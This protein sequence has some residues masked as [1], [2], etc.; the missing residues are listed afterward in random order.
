MIIVSGLM[1]FD[2]A[3]QTSV[4][5]AAREL[6]AAT[7]QEPGCRTYGL[8]SDPDRP[9]TFRIFEEWEDQESLTAHFATPHFAAFGE[10]L[11][12][13]G[14]VSMDVNRYID[15]TWT[16]FINTPQFPEYPS[17]H[18]VSS[19]AAATVL[20]QLLGT[21]AYVD[22]S[23][24]DRGMPS[25]HFASFQDAADE[26]ARSR[27]YGGIHFPMGVQGGI[28]HGAAIGRLVIERLSTRR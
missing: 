26:A 8:W 9:G 1:V 4:L 11:G 12:Q 20:T 7:L 24:R 22:D 10:R 6:T 28:A 2:P 3:S 18:S 27:I 5:D 13:L 16:T 25:R 15:P 14:L 21:V 17:G 19:N 23:H